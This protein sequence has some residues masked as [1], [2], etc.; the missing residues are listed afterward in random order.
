M[1]SR[2]DL[3]FAR[4]GLDALSRVLEMWTLHLFGA[5][6]AIHPVRQIPDERWIWHLGLDAEASAILNDAGM[7]ER[8]TRSG[9]PS[10][11]RCS[12]WNSAILRTCWRECGPLGL[13][14]PGDDRRRAAEAQAAEPSG[15]S[16]ARR[17]RVSPRR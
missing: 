10:S 15:Q 13:P 16:A 3:G 4:P 2:L 9:E 8:S 7:V 5:V 14:R 12:A 6:V 17:S 11:W 1:R